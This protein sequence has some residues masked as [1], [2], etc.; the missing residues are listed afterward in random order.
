MADGIARNNIRGHE[1]RT[2]LDNTAETRLSDKSVAKILVAREYIDLL[3]INTM[4][5]IVVIDMHNIHA[6]VTVPLFP[7]ACI[8]CDFHNEIE[9]QNSLIKQSYSMAHGVGFEELRRRFLQYECN[10]EAQQRKNPRQEDSAAE[11]K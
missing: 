8:I 3:E 5:T 2:N 10:P 4:Q 9:S 7:K 6:G 1:N 11:E